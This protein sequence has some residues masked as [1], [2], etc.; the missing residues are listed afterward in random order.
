[1]STHP[2]TL[3]EAELLIG[4]EEF[5]G[6]RGGPGGQHRNK[7]ETAVRVVH[8]ESGLEGQASE[9]RSQAENRR[10]A[11]RRLRWRL[12]VEVRE[13]VALGAEPSETWRRRVTQDGAIRLNAEHREAP[14]M[15]AEAMDWL[16][17]SGWDVPKAARRLGVTTSQ[18]VR[19][20]KVEP[21]ALEA[22]NRHRRRR[23]E[24]ALR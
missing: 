3:N 16:A 23:G 4:C 13:A 9:R 1:M 14:A 18:L 19:L 2:A 8:R 12:A 24:R 21:A 20:L 15:L 17:D 11:V 22:V 10:V 6:R 7:V 5:R